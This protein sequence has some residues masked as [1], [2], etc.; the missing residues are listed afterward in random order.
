M[1]LQQHGKQSIVSCISRLAGCTYSH[2]PASH[3]FPTPNDALQQ[4]SMHSEQRFNET[5]AGCGTLGALQQR[6]A[7]RIAQVAS[8]QACCGTHAP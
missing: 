6:E 1:S 8:A 4:M 3:P 5:A 7:A 2:A